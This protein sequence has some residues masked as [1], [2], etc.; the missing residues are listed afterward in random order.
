MSDNVFFAAS[1]LLMCSGLV[2]N[3]DNNFITG[4]MS[5][6]SAT[7]TCRSRNRTSL[8]HSAGILHQ[9]AAHLLMGGTQSKELK[10]FFNRCDRI[11][12][13]TGLQV[14]N[15]KKEDVSGQ[16]HNKTQNLIYANS[17]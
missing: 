9:S 2:R 5:K 15:I 10:V 1:V 12:V 11:W 7:T 8:F 3:R 4:L 17:P 6:K 16:V 14:Q 13:S